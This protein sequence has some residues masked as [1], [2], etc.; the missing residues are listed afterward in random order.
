MTNK[1]DTVQLDLILEGCGPQVSPAGS[2]GNI[3][4]FNLPVQEK[5]SLPEYN[6]PPAVQDRL[7]E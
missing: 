4:A 7:L 2:E 1:T 3:R 5:N 6:P